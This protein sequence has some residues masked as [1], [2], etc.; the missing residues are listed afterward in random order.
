MN[1]DRFS[2]ELYMQQYLDQDQRKLRY[3]LSSE[4][5]FKKPLF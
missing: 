5:G 2:G 1:I 4:C 3:I